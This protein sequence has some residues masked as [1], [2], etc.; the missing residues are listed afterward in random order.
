MNYIYGH[1]QYKMYTLIYSYIIIINVIFL[2]VMNKY[3]LFFGG[4]KCHRSFFIKVGH[5]WAYWRQWNTKF[6]SG[7]YAV[8]VVIH[9]IYY[10]RFLVTIMFNIFKIRDKVTKSFNRSNILWKN[11]LI[12]LIYS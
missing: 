8:T 3:V 1:L 11:K 5:F 2:I 10:H 9:H 6:K 12:P 4:M 7:T